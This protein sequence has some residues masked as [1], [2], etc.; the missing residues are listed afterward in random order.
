MRIVK[1]LPPLAACLFVASLCA[2][3]VKQGVR[4]LDTIGHGS[5]MSPELARAMAAPGGQAYGL[6]TKRLALEGRP[7][8]LAEKIMLPARPLAVPSPS[9]KPV[10]RWST[11]FGFDGLNHADSRL[12]S[13]GNQ[14]SVEPADQ[15][16]AVSGEQ[17][18][19]A[20]NDVLAVFSPK[21]ELLAGPTAAN[22]FFGLAPEIVRGDTNVYGPYLSDPQVLFDP[23]TQRWF[24]IVTE[25][26]VDP[27]SGNFRH[28][29]SV[30]I[31]VSQTAD[32][33]GRFDLYALDVTDAGFGRCP[34][35][36]DQ[37]LLGINADGLYISANQFSLND[38]RP[39]PR[40]SYA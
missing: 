37:P 1:L 13:G 28:H 20:T 31:A 40:P 34:C 33:T 36:A 12:A 6:E 5:L 16:L 24:L 23:D 9:L 17:V 35:L 4:R 30:L 32:A 38:G 19:Q 14:F 26:D 25:I 22:A 7:D 10:V 8:S 3:Q 27:A 15:A 29:A 21:A 39:S 18:F 2:A 11:S